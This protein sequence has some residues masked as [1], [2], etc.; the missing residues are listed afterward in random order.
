MSF[1]FNNNQPGMQVLKSAIETKKI[2]SN[3]VFIVSTPR[4]GSTMLFNLLM[5]GP[6]FWTIGC[7]S[8]GVYARFP[9]LKAE[10]QSLDSGCLTK[11]HADNETSESMRALYLSSIMN[12]DKVSYISA[13]QSGFNKAVCFLEKTPRNS[14]NIKFLMQ[15]FPDAKFIY[16]HRDAKQNISSMIE[17]WGVGKETGQFVTFRDLPDWPLKYWCFIL[18]PGWRKYKDKSIA[19][20]AA[21][22]WKSCNEIIMK[23]LSK[24]DKNRWMSLSYQDLIDNSEK[25]IKRMCKFSGVDFDDRLLSAA[26]NKRPLSQTTISEPHSEKWRRHES[27]IMPL[28]PKINATIKKISK[29]KQ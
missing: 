7:E 25:Q 17:A 20:I 23:N 22:Q 9:N 19:E 21:F 2:L 16:L 18:P 12:R 29:L 8:H 5:Q 10:N 15:V 1:I 14:L 4:S 27:E 3:A 13:E 24:L 6:D 28:L 11:A 26:K